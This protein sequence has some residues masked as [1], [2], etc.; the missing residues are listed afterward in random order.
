MASFA[1]LAGG[2]RGRSRRRYRWHLCIKLGSEDN[3]PVHRCIAGQ[4][5]SEASREQR[6]ANSRRLGMMRSGLL[7]WIPSLC[8]FSPDRSRGARRGLGAEMHKPPGWRGSCDSPSESSEAWDAPSAMFWL[9]IRC[10]RSQ[11][12]CDG[13]QD[14]R[15]R[16]KNKVYRP[17][18]AF[19]SKMSGFRAFERFTVR[20]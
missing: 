5:A 18:A 14:A 19:N 8:F 20:P 12:E 3:R 7:F 6:S 10:W 16:D 9:L 1:D 2:K 15:A 13:S 11:A 4:C 17:A